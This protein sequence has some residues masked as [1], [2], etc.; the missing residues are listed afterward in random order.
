MSGYG[1]KTSGAR[2]RRIQ[3]ENLIPNR[4]N[5]IPGSNGEIA[6]FA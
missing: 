6:S 4:I 5:N 2:R 3:E 1:V